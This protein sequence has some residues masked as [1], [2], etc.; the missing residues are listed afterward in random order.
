MDGLKALIIYGLLY[1]K[2]YNMLIYRSNLENKPL[3]I[4]T[5]NSLK[6]NACH[7]LL[8]FLNSLYV[9]TNCSSEM[10]TLICIAVLT[11]G[12]FFCMA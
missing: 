5:V 10:K 12:M 4:N 1:I 6:L 3:K 8:F 9:L 11:T 2:I 7:L